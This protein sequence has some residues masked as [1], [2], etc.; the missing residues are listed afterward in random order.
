MSTAVVVARLNT[1]VT[2]DVISSATHGDTTVMGTGTAGV[3]CAE[4]IGVLHCLAVNSSGI[5]VV[6]IEGS[7]DGGT[8][9]AALGTFGA[10]SATGITTVR[11][12]NTAPLV[13]WVSTK[14]SGTSVTCVIECIGLVPHDSYL[15]S[16]TAT[17]A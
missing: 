1:T 16:D 11:L 13:R 17:V 6:G 7:T 4:A 12:T 3:T 10:I 2:G 15:V 5:F 14:T 8:T 9:F